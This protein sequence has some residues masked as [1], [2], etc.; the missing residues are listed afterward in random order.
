MILKPT[1]QGRQ[2]YVLIHKETDAEKLSDLSKVTQ[3]RKMYQKIKRSTITWRLFIQGSVSALNEDIIHLGQL[4]VPLTGRRKPISAEW[5]FHCD[6]AKRSQCFI[7]LSF[8]GVARDEA[9]QKAFQ[10]KS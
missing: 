7:N 5:H 6:R 9:T 10:V 4:F 3:Q 2:Y 1:L 8:L